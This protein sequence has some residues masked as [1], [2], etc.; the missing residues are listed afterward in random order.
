MRLHLV[1]RR[2]VAVVDAVRDPKAITDL[3]H[4]RVF[5]LLQR[6]GVVRP[7]VVQGHR[8][9]AD[10]DDIL[11]LAADRIGEGLQMGFAERLILKS[12][13]CPNPNSSAPATRS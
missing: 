10:V 5:L 8:Q 13:R 1:D 7:E 3:L 6:D 9:A 11:A 2:L 12:V 4:F